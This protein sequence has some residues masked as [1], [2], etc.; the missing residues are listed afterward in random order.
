MPDTNTTNLNLVLPE[1]GGSDDTW[2]GPKLNANFTALDTIFNIT[3]TQVSLNINRAKAV[4]PTGAKQT[5]T[6]AQI[7]LNSA[8][9]F[10]T[11]VSGNIT[12][13]LTNVPATGTT[14]AFLLEL[15]NGGAH[16]VTWWSGIIDP[17]GTDPTLTA[18]G[19]DVLGF[20]THDGGTT[21]WRFT[22]LDVK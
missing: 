7:N 19:K 16:T 21:W 22:A 13:T 2:G 1:D 18:A 12:F 10:T 8:R 20:L 9:V 14:V 15:T 5:L 4:A 11:T 6:S 17:G 3:G